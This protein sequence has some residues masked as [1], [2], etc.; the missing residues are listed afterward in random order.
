NAATLVICLA[1]CCHFFM[2]KQNSKAATFNILTSTCNCYD[3]LPTATPVTGNRLWKRKFTQIEGYIYNSQLDW[4]I[5]VVTDQWIKHTD[6]ET[7][8]IADGGRLAVLDTDEKIAY[9]TGLPNVH[10]S[11]YYHLGADD[12]AVEDTF[13]WTTG[14]V[15]NRNRP[16]WADSQP[17]NDLGNQNCL[18]LFNHI[19]DDVFCSDTMNFICEYILLN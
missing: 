3:S 15:M 4:F 6:A 12:I 1:I 7:F 9:I 8:C 17:N 13:V 10:F 16:P 5:K 14:V 2:V 19:F 11:E 18:A